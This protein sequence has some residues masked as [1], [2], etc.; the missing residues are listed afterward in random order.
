MSDV[1]AGRS[2][3]SLSAAP[4]H[5][6]ARVRKYLGLNA[7]A[8]FIVLV[9]LLPAIDNGSFA[10][11]DEGL[12]SAQADALASGSWQRAR[13]AL[14]ADPNGRWS[15]LSSETRTAA[16]EIPYSR[17]PMYPLL[18]TPFWQVGGVAGGMLLSAAGTC[19]AALCSGLI[20]RRL[21]PRLGAPVLWLV[22]LGSPLLYD[23]YLLV[24]HSLAAAF[25]AGLALATLNA[26]SQLEGQCHTN[27]RF[28][29]WTVLSC[30]AAV[31]LVAIRTEG[32]LVSLA[33]SAA[34]VLCLI[35]WRK[36]FSRQVLPYISFSG[37]LA[38][39]ALATYALNDRWARAVTV[40]GGGDVTAFDRKI[41]PVNAL[42]SSVLRPWHPDN[43]FAS[44]TMLLV[45]VG[46]VT[47]PLLLRWVP[48]L[49]LFALASL[50][51]AAGASA[52]RMVEYPPSLISGFFATMPWLVIGLLS[53]D[54]AALDSLSARVL[55]S[56]SL[57]TFVAVLF[58][59]YGDGGVTEWGG[60][61]FHVTIPLLAPIGAL[62]LLGLLSRLSRMEK[63]VVIS[64]ILAMTIS[65]SVAALRE[66]SETRQLTSTV[67]EFIVDTAQ[68]THTNLVVF[69]QVTGGG[70]PRMFWTIGSRPEVVATRGIWTLPELLDRLPNDR[71]RVLVL[72]DAPPTALATIVGKTSTDSWTIVA[73]R[74]GPG[75]LI[76]AYV[77]ERK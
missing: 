73:G 35:D 62:G 64:S 4:P 24:A 48:G 44:A 9:A 39:T 45:V 15:A 31:P 25:S 76:N 11:P 22:G 56:A 71:N 58:T 18:L 2:A 70:A 20:A 50:V 43:R 65:L 32:V 67:R 51:L 75:N 38:A 60:R 57:L 30:T 66:N 29:M 55:L 26:I 53:I 33:I 3:S 61:F 5:S 54:R 1:C 8:L 49:R 69:S 68:A 72:T 77:L 21:G 47:A 63:F 16:R 23:A 28:W 36:P 52:V 17:R 14:D 74:D 46:S 40:G 42:W 12:Y 19:V 27:S 13:P 7:V 59:T 10:N 37:L 34:V 6:L 41:N